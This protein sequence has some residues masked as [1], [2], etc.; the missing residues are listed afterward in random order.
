MGQPIAVGWLKFRFSMTKQL[1]PPLTLV[2]GNSLVERGKLLGR[3]NDERGRLPMVRIEKDYVFDGPEGQRSL[4]GLFDGRL[5]LIV[6][7]FMFA[8]A[9]NEG[10]PGL[11]V[12]YS[13]PMSSAAG[14]GLVY[15][16]VS[17]VRRSR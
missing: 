16:R 2:Q 9:S 12:R 3:L 5:Q 10:C 4:A 14:A 11:G 7:H 17:K 15:E 6:Y 1:N 8:P 13:Q